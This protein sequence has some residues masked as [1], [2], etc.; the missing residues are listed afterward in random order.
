MQARLLRNSVAYRVEAGPSYQLVLPP[1][2]ELLMFHAVQTRKGEGKNAFTPP[3][4][5][6]NKLPARAMEIP[7]PGQGLT[8]VRH[9]EQRR[10]FL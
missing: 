2:L 5:R 8:A 6:Q 9:W 1:P 10:R 7:S 4:Q 3:G